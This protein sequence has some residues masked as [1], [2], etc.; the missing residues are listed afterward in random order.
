MGDPK[1]K[2][3]PIPLPRGVAYLSAPFFFDATKPRRAETLREYFGCERA[4]PT[5]TRET[6]KTFNN[7]TD[8]PAAVLPRSGAGLLQNM[9]DGH[10]A[11]DGAIFPTLVVVGQLDSYVSHF[12]SKEYAS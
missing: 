6:L 4:I 2:D 11:L 12:I 8:D 3:S 10:P 1:R 5:E 7:R 9:P